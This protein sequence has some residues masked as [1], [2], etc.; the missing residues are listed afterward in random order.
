MPHILI[1][2]DYRDN[3]DVT[4]LILQDAGYQVTTAIN[5]LYGVQLATQIRP[6]LI[7]MDLGLPIL[8]GW[9]AMRRLKASPATRSIPIIALTAFVSPEHL[10]SARAA[11]CLTVIT[12]PFEIN[13]LLAQV[14]AGV[15]THN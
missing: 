10:D 9:E 15:A 11:G 13:D 8:N 12:K 7:L 4:E 14:E 1:I 3:R 6:D 5:G 2:E